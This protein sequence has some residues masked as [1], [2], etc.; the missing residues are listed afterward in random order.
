MI[1]YHT[2]MNYRQIQITLITVSQIAAIW[3]S[4]LLTSSIVYTPNKSFEHKEL[5]SSSSYSGANFDSIVNISYLLNSVVY[6]WYDDLEFS[7]VFLDCFNNF[8]GPMN[9]N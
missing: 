3:L 9:V 6:Y 8:M 5:F 4:L 2:V 7:A 1:L